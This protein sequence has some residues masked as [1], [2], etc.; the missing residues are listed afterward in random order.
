MTLSGEIDRKLSPGSRLNGEFDAWILNVSSN[1]NRSAGISKTLLVSG[2]DICHEVDEAA[3]RCL[4]DAVTHSTGVGKGVFLSTMKY[5]SE[6]FARTQLKMWSLQG[7][8]ATTTADLWQSSLTHALTNDRPKLGL[9]IIGQMLKRSEKHTMLQVFASL[10]DDVLAKIPV[11]WKPYA[12]DLVS[13]HCSNQSFSQ[14]REYAVTPRAK[15]VVLRNIAASIDYPGNPDN[16][17]SVMRHM[18]KRSKYDGDSEELVT[19]HRSAAVVVINEILAMD[20]EDITDQL[21]T[22]E[23][24]LMAFKLGL[25]SVVQSIQSLQVRAKAFAHALAI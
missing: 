10:D 19:K 4:I 5:M 13:V 9:D 20:D 21:N 24:R 15:E 17:A 1:P 12:E 3:Y 23:L 8:L 18:I 16:W 22:D 14:A 6:T 25:E 2:Q 7:V 11:L